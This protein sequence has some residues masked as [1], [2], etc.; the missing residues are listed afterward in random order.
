MNLNPELQAKFDETISRIVK[1]QNLTIEALT[2]EQVIS[3]FKQA[4]LS[5]DFQKNVYYDGNLTSQSVIY[6]PYLEVERLRSE[7]EKMKKVIEELKETL[8][9]MFV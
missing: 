2:E 8:N 3:V 4:I 5:G 1:E 7:N 6:I 9:V